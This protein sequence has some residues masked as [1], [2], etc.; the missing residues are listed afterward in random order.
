MSILK[1]YE[2]D[3]K[4]INY[5]KPEKQGVIYY[6][7]MNYD[8]KPFYL[9]TP[10][11]TC[12]NGF[13]DILDSKNSLLDL[14]PVNMDYSFY[15][16]LL[17]LDERNIKCTFEN[18][19]DWFG[20][21]I[22]LEIIDN[23]YKRNNKPVK[24]DS[25]PRFSYKIPLIK[26]KVQCQIY[27][28][29]RVCVDFNKIQENIEVVLILHVKG[30][31]FLKQHYYCDIYISQIKVFLDGDNKYSIL[32]TYSFNDREEEE[33]ELKSLE[34]ELMLDAD[35]IQGFQKEK[36]EKEKIRKELNSAKENYEIYKNK[37]KDL[38]TQLS[39]F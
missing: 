4:K 29:K 9:Q 8:N 35:F 10:K 37:V 32:D 21:N 7:S 19:K 33:Q 1:H 12:K 3:F 30:L 38:E 28:Q 25:K 6:A 22:P 13:Q 16:S 26:D 2:L 39:N 36:E 11:M 20:K 17:S 23:M 18:N 14:E 15:D 34:K 24:K 5:N 27:D 31:K